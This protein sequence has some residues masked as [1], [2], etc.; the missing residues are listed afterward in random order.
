M[1]KVPYR[2]AFA[3]DCP[4]CGRVVYG[5]VVHIDQARESFPA[6][7]MSELAAAQ[8]SG[9]EVEI[10]AVAVPEWVECA[11]CATRFGLAEEPPAGTDLSWAKP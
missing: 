7:L 2:Y 11:R 5:P 4:V 6:S 9:V 10:G 1:Q 3:A 8:A